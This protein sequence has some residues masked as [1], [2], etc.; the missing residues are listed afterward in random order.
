MSASH[1]VPGTPFAIYVLGFGIFAIVTSEF[2]VSGMMP[3]MA[4]EL[5]VSISRVGYLVSLYSFAMAVGGPLLAMVLLKTPLKTA[6]MMLYAVFIV[7]ESLGALAQ[8]YTLLAAARLITG[9][10]S[11]AVFGIALAICVQL[12]SEAQRGW[13]TSIVLA[14]IMTGTVLGLPM[15]NM[16]G[17]HWGWRESFWATACIA[18]VAAII[19]SV[20]VPR[21]AL[22][23]SISLRHEL[24]SLKNTRLWAAFATS[25]LVIGATFAAF[26]YFIPLLKD[27][28]G[29]DDNAVA[30]LLFVYGAAT[31]VGNLIVGKFADRYT[32][33]ALSVGLGLLLLFLVLFGLFAEHAA[34]AALSLIGIGLVG[35]TMNPA[36]VARVMKVANGRPL[37][38][39][40]HTSVITLGIVI[41]SFLGGLFIGAGYSLRAPLW[42]GAAM[43]M[44]GLLT[45]LPELLESA[46]R[47]RNVHGIHAE[48]GG[49]D[50]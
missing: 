17:T 15:A 42:V 29:F 23:T 11:G 44:A 39:T 20:A 47:N 48:N 50:G 41:G 24:A 33:T 25:L 6:L 12:V 37:V 9:A 38:N 21:V 5:S 3:V 8:S 2:Q 14:G 46:R 18:A 1:Q 34:M 13:A 19:T 40:V 26:T 7:G 31:V 22:Q 45:L 30:A 32:L 28:A 43:A 4:A 36:M 35:V 10:A 49:Q 16:I 27:V